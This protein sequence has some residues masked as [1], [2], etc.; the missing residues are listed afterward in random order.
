MKRE[1]ITYLEVQAANHNAEPKTF[2][3]RYTAAIFIALAVFI[4]SAVATKT[5]GIHI[6]H[7]LN[8]DPQEALE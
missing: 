7:Q 8:S 1:T 5:A 2:L 4:V 6:Y 3:Q